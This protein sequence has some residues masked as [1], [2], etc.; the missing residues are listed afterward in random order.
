MKN[1][2]FGKLVSATVSWTVSQ[3]LQTS[4]MKSVVVLTDVIFGIV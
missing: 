3:D 2:N 4:L 1:K